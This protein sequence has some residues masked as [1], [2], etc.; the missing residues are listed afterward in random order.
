M[1]SNILKERIPLNILMDILDKYCFI[2]TDKYY[3]LD[4]DTYKKIVLENKM[5]EFLEKIVPYYKKTKLFYVTRQM[6][7]VYFLTIV[8]HIC[9][10]NNVKYTST[11]YYNRSK[12]YIKYLIYKDEIDNKEETASN[13]DS[14]DAD[15]E[16]DDDEN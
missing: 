12:H 5:D 14:S 16:N 6:K 15:D 4:L 7:Y 10:S 8:R 13:H 3:T 11:I 1:S 9:N 2:K